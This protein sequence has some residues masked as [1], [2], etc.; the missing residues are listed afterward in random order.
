MDAERLRRCDI[1]ERRAFDVDG[2]FVPMRQHTQGQAKYAAEP[3]RGDHRALGRLP[4][5]EQLGR[6]LGDGFDRRAR[7]L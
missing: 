4:F 3:F 7:H 6:R 1:G 5:V 2:E